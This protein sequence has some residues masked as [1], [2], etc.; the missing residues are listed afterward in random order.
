MSVDR[1]PQLDRP[2]NRRPTPND[3]LGISD[4]QAEDAGTSKLQHQIAAVC[5]LLDDRALKVTLALA[6]ALLKEPPASKHRADK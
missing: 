4:G 1:L 6:T 2:E 3:L 5:R